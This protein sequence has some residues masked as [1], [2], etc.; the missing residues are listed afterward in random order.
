[1]IKNYLRSAWRNITRHKFIS[2]I[3]IFGLTV[4]L[5]CCLLI[6]TYIFNELS[7]DK[8]N[9]KADRTY[10]VTRIFYTQQG[11]ESLHLSAV[12]PP[13][14]PLLQTAFPDIEKMTRVLPN[15][16]TVVHYKE[17]VF[18]E[19]NAF[20]ADE[21][22]TSVFSL[23]V[24]KGDSRTALNEPYTVMLTEAM[25]HKY[26][27]DADPI[28]KTIALDNN[29]HEYKVTGVFKPFPVN[30]HMHPEILISFN[31]LKD[32]LV[33][34]EKQLR[35]NFGNNSF[36]TYLLFP[37]GANAERVGSQLSWFLDKYV[38]FNGMPPNIKTS[39][40]TQLT[41]QKLTDIHLRSHLDDEIENNGDI[42]RVYIFS[43]IALF[44]LL[45]A[46][47]NYMNL[48][49]ARSMLRAKEIGIRKVVGAQQKE[50]IRQFLSESVL[51]T[52]IAL[53]LAI[54][55]SALTLPYI[56]KVSGLTLSIFSLLN[57]KI[58]GFIIAMPFIVGLISGIYPAMFMSSFK[59]VRVLK[60]LIKTGA[61]GL[62]FRKVL[63]VLQFS[64][65]IVLIVATTVVFQQLQFI[66][67]KSL[68]FNKD[69]VLNMGYYRSLNPSFDSFR[70]ELLK[71]P[72]IKEAGRSSRVPSGRL[73]DD[74]NASVMQGDSLQPIKLDL[75]YVT[76]DYGFI[77]A[78]G[79][80]IDAGRNFSRSYVSDTSN[81][82]IN[83]A[84]VQ[85]L[86]W[87][88]AQNAIGKD[89][90]Y[91]RVKGKVIGV[92]NDFHFESL[93][94]KIIPL[95][96]TLPAQGYYNNLSIKVDGNNM[97][98]A[99]S[100]I[101]T[102]WHHYLPEVPFDYTFM[103][104]KFEQLYNSEQLQGSLFTIFACIAIFI[105]CLGL[106]GLSA[107]TISQR[108]KEI[109]V[110][111]VLGASVPQIVLELSKDFLKLVLV[112]AIISLPI[113]WYAMTIY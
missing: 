8:F 45:I 81:F 112:A 98:S 22:F 30:A 41:L 21:N 10:R 20:C 101:E 108:F 66:Q 92:M 93:H 86:G 5:A 28:D 67:N 75:K 42:T 83:E 24:T 74:Q 85:M 13:F 60:G 18:N 65:S 11:V 82:I 69:Y 58:L 56:N 94:Q 16:S 26:F 104:K 1:M 38:H 107:F 70:D 6:I 84:A 61:G 35:T 62:S 48:S 80:H 79:I 90:M 32:S 7:Y 73:L 37:K 4:G 51:I 95:L 23:D 9:E 100:T 87:K 110:R 47:I 111:K 49:T 88:N 64:I 71:N 97:R 106:F 89:M 50:I 44:I 102:T 3:N 96:L 39:N 33:Y 68:G 113:A 15:G 52:W 54:I 46:C 109:G 63:V 17:K 103:D 19:N 25:A 55:I 14:G 105:A 43:V 31:T 36:Y 99:I 29:K 78:Y 34:G 12:A 91:G 72:A 76:A 77:P 53:V 27:G 40:V 57:W 59:P 2:F